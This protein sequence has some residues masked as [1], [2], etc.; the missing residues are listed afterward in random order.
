METVFLHAIAHPHA[1]KHY[2]RYDVFWR[3]R[4]IV[5]SSRDPES[6]AARELVTAGFCAKFEVRD[7]LTGKSRSFCNASRLAR[8]RY[9]DGD[10]KLARTKWSPYPTPMAEAAE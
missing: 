3:G 10:T 8:F 7:R 4:R 5:Q 1:K 2:Y 9:S 6:D